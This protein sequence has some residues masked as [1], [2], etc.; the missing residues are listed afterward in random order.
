MLEVDCYYYYYLL[1]AGKMTTF[2]TT[3]SFF[4]EVDWLLI[5]C[6]CGWCVNGESRNIPM[7][8][9]WAGGAQERSMY[10]YISASCSC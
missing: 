1:R 2:I 6:C 7:L 8:T 9:I 4:V 5:A 10:T 3:L